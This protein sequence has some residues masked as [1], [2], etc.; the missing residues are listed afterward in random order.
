MK[1]RGEGKKSDLLLQ[2]YKKIY[3]LDFSLEN[4]I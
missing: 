4:N 2:Y 3:R 1:F